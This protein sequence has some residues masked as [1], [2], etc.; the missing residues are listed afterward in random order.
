MAAGED[1]HN[2]AAEALSRVRG[3]V[4]PQP[5][6]VFVYTLLQ[7]VGIRRD[8]GRKRTFVAP[9]DPFERGPASAANESIHLIYPPMLPSS[10]LAR[11]R[12][13]LL[14]RSERMSGIRPG[15]TAAWPRIVSWALQRLASRQKKFMSQIPRIGCV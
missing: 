8:L 12:L 6:A 3:G 11:Q 13:A 2:H 15:I 14:F 7:R 5:L 1:L 4:L 9:T 10:P